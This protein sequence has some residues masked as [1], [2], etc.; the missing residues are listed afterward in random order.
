[1]LEDLSSL[2][3]LQ[4][5]WVIIGRGG[6]NARFHL[7]SFLSFIEH[8]CFEK[9]IILELQFWL[10]WSADLTA[11]PSSQTSKKHKKIYNHLS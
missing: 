9:G 11:Q 2:Y 1:M 6:E 8:G 3:S 7:I 10:L 4:L 5:K